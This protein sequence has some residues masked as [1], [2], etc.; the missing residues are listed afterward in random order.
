M[1]ARIPERGKPE[2]KNHYLRQ[3]VRGR[4]IADCVPWLSGGTPLPAVCTGH[5]KLYMIAKEKEGRLSVGLWNFHA[6]IVWEPV[7]ELGRDYTTLRVLNGGCGSLQGKRVR[8]EAIPAF[9]SV[10]FEVEA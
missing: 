2:K 7:V 5:P 9:G 4:Q 3:Y 10:F 6:D 8:L 1:D